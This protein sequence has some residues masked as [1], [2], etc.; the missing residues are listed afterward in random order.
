MLPGWARHGN[1]RPQNG[2]FAKDRA[3]ASLDVFSHIAAAVLFLSEP[4]YTHC[5]YTIL[6]TGFHLY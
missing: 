3:L 2:R 5:Q 6:L 1:Y 4:A